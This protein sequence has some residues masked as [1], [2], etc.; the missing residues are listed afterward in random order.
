MTDAEWARH[1]EVPISTRTHFSGHPPY[2]GIKGLGLAL[3]E[4]LDELA[5]LRNLEVVARSMRDHL[6]RQLSGSYG[7][8]TVDALAQLVT[9][10]DQFQDA[11]NAVNRVRILRDA[12]LES[13][14]FDELPDTNEKKVTRSYG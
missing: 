6:E 10:T 8:M 2:N 11:Q 14:S 13:A 7:Q 3:E 1:I 5:G 9:L 12:N 4:C